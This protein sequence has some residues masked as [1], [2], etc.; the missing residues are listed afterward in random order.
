MPQ[1]QGDIFDRVAAPKQAPQAPP[2]AD[3]FDSLT[4]I[5]SP[6]QAAKSSGKAISAPSQTQNLPLMGP[7]S[8]NAPVPVVSPQGDIAGPE[9]YDP[10]A[11]HPRSFQYPQDLTPTISSQKVLSTIGQVVP[12]FATKPLGEITHKI[13]EPFN[14]YLQSAEKAGGQMGVEMYSALRHPKSVEAVAPSHPIPGITY[15][16]NLTAHTEQQDP[17]L[18]GIA[19]GVGGLAAS[20]VADPRNWPFLFAGAGETAIKKLI[21]KGFSMQMIGGALASS[22]S[23]H[24]AIKNGDYEKA[25]EEITKASIGFGLGT[26]SAIHGFGGTTK[27]IADLPKSE[28]PTTAP[29]VPTQEVPIEVAPALEAQPLAKSQPM[30]ISEMAV[31]EMHPAEKAELK[32]QAGRDL[33]EEEAQKLRRQ[34]V[35]NASVNQMLTGTKPVDVVAQVRAKTE[36]SKDIF[37]QVSTPKTIPPIPSNPLDA[38]IEGISNEKLPEFKQTLE[39]RAKELQANAATTR[40]LV[41]LSNRNKPNAKTAIAIKA[42]GRPAYP[43][44]TTGPSGERVV[45]TDENGKAIFTKEKSEAG[46]H[47]RHLLGELAGY[48]PR[49]NLDDMPVR[50]A[51]AKIP[52]AAW[53]KAIE[54]SKNEYFQLQNIIRDGIENANSTGQDIDDTE[55]PSQ[56]KELDRLGSRIW[57]IPKDIS[58]EGRRTQLPLDVT[59]PNKAVNPP[60]LWTMDKA[61]ADRLTGRKNKTL[62]SE[63]ELLAHADKQDAKAAKHLELASHIQ[64]KLDA[65][66]KQL[67]VGPQGGHAGG[68]VSSVEELNRPGRF[69]KISRSGI[70]S[71]QNKVPDFNLGPGEAGYQVKPDGSIFLTAGQETPITRVGVQNFAKQIFPQE[72]IVSPGQKAVESAGGVYKATWDNGMVEAVLPRSMTEDL[73]IDPRQ[74]G[75]VSITI[76]SEHLDPEYIK[77]AMAAKRAEIIQ[78]SRNNAPTPTQPVPQIAPPPNLEAEQA[79]ARIQENTQILQQLVDPKNINSASDVDA[80]LTNASERLKHNQDPRI[81]V[82]L[83]AEARTRLASSLGMAEKDIFSEASGQGHSAEEITAAQMILDNSRDATLKAMTEARADNTKIDSA[84]AQLAKHNEI[85]EGIRDKFAKEAGRALQAVKKITPF[86]Q[87]ISDWSKMDPKAKIEAARRFVQLDPNEPGA[88]ERFSKDIRPTMKRSAVFETYVNSLLSGAAALTKFSSDV[89][90]LLTSLP[91]KFVNGLVDAIQAPIF[92]RP[93]QEFAGEALAQAHGFLDGARAGFQQFIKTFKTE[94]SPSLIDDEFSKFDH[95]IKRKLGRAIRIPMRTL[96]AITDGFK[97]INYSGRLRAIAYRNAVK[98]GL[99]PFSD[100]GNVFINKQ[101]INPTLKMRNEAN[102][103]ANQQVLQEDYSGP[104]LYNETMR[105]VLAARS[106]SSL[107]KVVVPFAKTPGNFAREAAKFSPV[108]FYGTVKEAIVDRH[109][110]KQATDSLEAAKAAQKLHSNDAFYQNKVDKAAQQIKAIQ[111]RAFERRTSLSKNILGTG[112]FL[113]ALNYALKGNITGAGPQNPKIR[114]ALISTGWQPYSVKI[115]D[116]YVSYRRNPQAFVSLG[117][118]ADIAEAMKENPGRTNLSKRMLSGLHK[119]VALGT[120][121]TFL[122]SLSS[123]YRLIEG[124]ENL[125]QTASY[126][127]VPA[128]VRYAAHIIDSR[129]TDPRNAAQQFEAQIPFLSEKVPSKIDVTGQPETLLKKNLGGFNPFSISTAKDNAALLEQMRLQANTPTIPHVTGHRTGG[130]GTHAPRINITPDEQKILSVQDEQIN[131][132]RINAFIRNPGYRQLT[133]AQKREGIAHIQR[134]TQLSRIYRLQQLRAEQGPTK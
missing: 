32:V 116:T 3:I 90:M 42:T 71:D 121:I 96:A 44:T 83:T 20:T 58:P 35:L 118:A 112:A 104:G 62:L 12:Q 47:S 8:L 56:L 77:N 34:N 102:S 109:L 2:K 61:T 17:I 28:T 41:D 26:L 86:D 66:K 59:D 11:P 106:K 1:Q 123:M 101:L 120:D 43:V 50:P 54:I 14:Q 5:A 113:F 72:K 80:A 114:Q 76:P 19:K 100:E 126:E 65:S 64:N 124:Q 38:M 85:V 117:T 74:K 98:V 119:T 23:A 15:D 57:Q 63:E 115:G 103:F 13:I 45:V 125:A 30:S 97:V 67:E 130:F 78:R 84:I 82:P 21:S 92:N 51:P 46:I 10:N 60:S 75:F 39:E 25:A 79:A 87:A 55:V 22:P 129:V 88:I 4:S 73:P 93:R 105:A 6:P 33:S 68:G 29:L 131:N 134:Q 89:S 107:A 40:Q 37:D 122:N 127:V 27:P 91:E 9:F 31:P 99:N 132:Q 7:P 133:D 110:L 48:K 36:P 95:A 70:P 81:T 108:G 16:P 49:F 24:Q 52:K 53:D 128:G 94:T 69:V 111:T 18:T